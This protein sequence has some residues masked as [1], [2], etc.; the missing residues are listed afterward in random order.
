MSA[1]D[2]VSPGIYPATLPGS[3]VVSP[4]RPVRLIRRALVACEELADFASAAAGMVASLLLADTSHRYRLPDTIAIGILAGILAVLDMRAND[5]YIEGGSL[6][7]I[8]ETERILR[9]GIRC[10]LFIAPV[11]LVLT[12]GISKTVFASAPVFVVG[13]MILQKRCF[14][15]ALRHL[16]RTRDGA[17]RVVV[18]GTGCTERRVASALSQCVRLGLKPVA[19]ID[20]S[21][22]AADRCILELG[23]RGRDS[24]KVHAAPITPALLLACGCNTLVISGGD[25]S[26]DQR[27]T[28]AQCARMAGARVAY[29]SDSRSESVLKARTRRTDGLSIDFE[30]ELDASEGMYDI[31]KRL[32]DV[33]LSA[34]AL[35]VLLPVFLVIAL[36]IR[37]DSPGPI[38]FIQD[39]V[40]RGGRLFKIFKFRSMYPNCS[41]YEPSPTTPLDP[42]LT[43]VG[44]IL[45]RLSLDELPQFVNVLLGTMSLVGPRPEMPFIAR[46][47]TCA[48]RERLH[49][50]PGITGLWQLSADRAFPIHENLEY[51]LYY[52]RHRGVFM[53]LAI[54]IHTVVFAMRAGI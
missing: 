6:L 41:T 35:M 32:L 51:D 26:P 42:R 5:A 11:L 52:I 3:G 15:L 14:F 24:I 16:D 40:G 12:P 38:I 43:R 33:T 2:H 13:M 47:Y 21:P 27:T 44:K 8:R 22:G 4:P 1:S 50:M 36:L 34:L 19:F 46:S 29:L 31:I 10:V 25:V 9:A 39:R 45:R 30:G 17:E 54:L 37:L 23:Y 48:E 7:H 28:A 49:V 18:Y 20:D 53:D